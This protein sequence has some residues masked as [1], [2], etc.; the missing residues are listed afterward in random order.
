MSNLEAILDRI[1]TYIYLRSVHP[2][3]WFEDF[4]KLRTGR[5]TVDQFHRCLETVKIQL[6]NDEFNT[7]AEEYM[8]NGYVNY[9][10]FIDTIQDVFSDKDMEK[11]PHAT[12]KNARQV[13]SRT[14][15]NIDSGNFDIKYKALF[16]KLSHQIST[17]GVHIRESYQDF[18]RHNTGT[19]TQSQF[20]RAL[21]FRDLTAEEMQMLIQRYADPILRDVNYRRLITDINSFNNQNKPQET[22]PATQ[23]RGLNSL[24]PHQ[25]ASIK[26][27]SFNSNPDTLIQNFAAHVREKRVRI[28][29]FFQQHDPLN[30][31]L[32]TVP[33][34]ESTLVLFGFTFTEEDL[35]YL[36]SQYE[37]TV[38]FT[39][40]VR[41]LEFCHDVDH[42]ENVVEQTLKTRSLSPPSTPGLKNV[43]DR[44]KEI[45]IRFRMNVL[46]TLQD[47]DRQNRGYITKIQFRRALSTLKIQ[48]T[49]QELEL[50]AAEYEH[51]NGVDYYKFIED[52]DSTHKQQR[53]AFKPI[54]TDKQSIEDVFGKTPTGDRF[55]TPD[56]ADEMIY[57]SKHGLLT[58]ID[59]HHEINSLLQ[60]LKRWS[61]INSVDFHDF[62]SDFD[63]H[64]IGEITQGQFRSGMGLSTYK[65]TDPEFELIVQNYSSPTRDGFIQW[66][67]FSDDIIQSIAPLELTKDPTTTPPPPKDTFN[68]RARVQ[69]RTPDTIPPEVERLL[70]IV[71][72]FVK[73][74]RISLMEQF[75]DK[76]RFNHKRVTATGFAQV[77]QLIGVHISKGE[78]DVLCHYYNDT[79]TNFVDYTLFVQDVEAKVG[80]IFGDRA[81][82]SIVMN[83]IPKYGNEDSP[84]L[85]SK[86]S[87]DPDKETWEDIKSKL[88]TFVY[89]RR[90]RIQ[91]F[92]HSFDNLN[93]GYVTHQKF[94]SV[95]G[96]TDLPLT[97]YQ[98][99]FLIKIFTVPDKEDMFDYR[100]FC[101]QVNKIFGKTE[102]QKKP[103]DKGK[104]K[105]QALPDPSAT[106]QALPSQEQ[107]RIGQIIERMKRMVITRRMN[108]REQF[109]DYDKAP[110]KNFITKQQFKQCI[111]RLGLSTDPRE[112]DVLCKK[113]RCTDLDDMNYQAFCNDI[114]SE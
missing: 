7:L 48:I 62:L 105:T 34:F 102:L 55:V 42:M 74:R 81:S 70:E 51:E 45:I 76:D 96:Q 71:A 84:Y 44:I 109:A 92:F 86:L 37:E 67:R 94:R 12:C 106:L 31:G 73:S 112:F 78:I 114:E 82:T 57:Q 91:E 113:Y 29:E 27:R 63:P 41:Y 54:G 23:S 72:R 53:R 10:R 80:M 39:K 79:H 35:H 89:K 25:L 24:L 100:T 90:I 61:Y 110:H 52:V 49:D 38:N 99:D 5:V 28:K 75:K 87:Y 26:T 97:S 9:R 14:L 95:I 60:E 17:R 4:D 21:P 111:A 64:K 15:G 6:N 103:V 43:V 83:P 36:S 104:P 16:A 18:D 65:L 59:E 32:V 3:E 98:I 1:R 33:K 88:Q 108:I 77:I 66:R 107:M 13:V 47:F 56:Q 101:H 40:Y 20:L 93:L 46:P 85:V 50:L 22:F 2:T 8:D 68:P 19:V 30:K 11:N 58:K 69:D